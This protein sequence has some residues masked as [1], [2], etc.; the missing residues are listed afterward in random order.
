[1]AI[2]PYL[3]TAIKHLIFTSSTMIY[4][5]NNGPVT[6]ESPLDD[7]ERVQ[8]LSQV[9]QFLLLL[10][11]IKTTILRLG[12]LYGPDREIGQFALKKKVILK[13]HPVNLIHQSDVITIISQLITAPYHGILNAVSDTHPTRYTLYQQALNETELSKI[14]FIEDATTPYKIVDNT[15][16]K[17]L[18][19]FK[20]RHQL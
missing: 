18:L 8:V 5:A 10:P 16:L 15:K 20:F 6:E 12:G 13:N 14:K 7:T 11:D 19:H 3:S 4:Q 9:E 17:R 1:M 2:K